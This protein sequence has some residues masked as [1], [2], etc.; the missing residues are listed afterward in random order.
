MT[1][2]QIVEGIETLRRKLPPGNRDSFVRITLCNHK[3][4]VT[5]EVNSHPEGFGYLGVARTLES[6]VKAALEHAERKRL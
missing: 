5:L 6:V 4:C 2:A 1:P 3:D